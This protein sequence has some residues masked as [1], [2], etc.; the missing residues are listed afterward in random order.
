MSH[1][2][3]CVIHRSAQRLELETLSISSGAG[4]DTQSVIHLVPSGMIFV[5]SE[6]GK[7]HR[8]DEWT[9]WSPLEKGVN[10]LLHSLHAM[11]YDKRSLKVT[12]NGSDSA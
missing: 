4:H 6:G 3:Q 7:C 11:I 10:V 1:A 9:D 5:P 8:R 2:I 12:D